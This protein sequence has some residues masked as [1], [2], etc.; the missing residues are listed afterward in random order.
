M[1]LQDWL[2]TLLDKL[3]FRFV[4]YQT[5]RIRLWAAIQVLRGRPV[6]CGVHVVQHGTGIYFTQPGGEVHFYN[7]TFAYP[8]DLS[9]ID[10]ARRIDIGVGDCQL[11]F[12]DASRVPDLTDK[13]V[14]YLMRRARG[15]SARPVDTSG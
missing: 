6:I 3:L 1:S 2:T 15:G 11:N 13:V 5:L 8:W 12:C 4:C 9:A 7:S 10:P 14:D